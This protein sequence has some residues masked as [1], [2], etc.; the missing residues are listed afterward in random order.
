VTI[1]VTAKTLTKVWMGWEDFEQAVK[2][3]TLRFLGPK[4]YTSIAKQWL[5]HSTVAHIKKRDKSLLVSDR[6]N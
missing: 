2:R 3:Q 1:Q 6:I 4:K 5:G